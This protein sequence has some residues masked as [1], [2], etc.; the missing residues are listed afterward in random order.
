MKKQNQT[1]MFLYIEQ[2][3]ICAIFSVILL[4]CYIPFLV[5]SSNYGTRTWHGVNIINAYSRWGVPVFFMIS[6][7]LLLNS[8]KQVVLIDFLKNKLIRILLPFVFYSIIY[9]IYYLKSNQTN[10]SILQFI[11]RFANGSLAPHLW[12]VFTLF[13]IYL[14]VPIFKKIV[15]SVNDSILW[16][17][18]GLIFFSNIINYSAQSLNFNIQII[19]SL[20]NI[21][22]AYFLY[23]YLIDKIDFS[24]NQ[25]YLIYL[26]GFLGGVYFSVGTYIV[27]DFLKFKFITG[28]E[29]CIY[30]LSTAIF[31]FFKYDFNVFN[32]LKIV[33]HIILI[34]GK[35]TYGVYL[36][37][38]II[39]KI[40]QGIFVNEKPFVQIILVSILT[41]V[42][43]YVILYILNIILRKYP[44]INLQITGCKSIA[45][46]RS[47]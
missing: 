42:L 18:V 24:R 31:V 36:A 5:D 30:L 28:Y 33:Q 9:Y 39:M 23:G 2:L 38:I 20:V 17:L 4:H 6:G 15:I 40:L 44:Y 14:Y 46:N 10:G 45:M 22:L 16:Y 19:V 34:M 35:L 26:I 29:I 13:S 41:F 32:N 21:Y 1:K 3:R 7:K 25:R 47:K 8:K 27:C 12:F 43:S 11:T 37:H